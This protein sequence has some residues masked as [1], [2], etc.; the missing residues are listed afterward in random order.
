MTYENAVSIVRKHFTTGLIW[1]YYEYDG[2]YIFAVSQETAFILPDFTLH[3]YTVDETG[4]V[5]DYD[6]S[7]AINNDLEGFKKTIKS[8][9]CIDITQ[10]EFNSI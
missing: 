10:E 3:H 5:V 4:E 1:F 9:K 8:A 6:T 2:K 7:Y